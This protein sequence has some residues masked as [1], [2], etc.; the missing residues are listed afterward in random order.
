MSATLDLAHQTRTNCVETPGSDLAQMN[1]TILVSAQRLLYC[2]R[3][4][5][6]SSFGRGLPEIKQLSPEIPILEAEC[7]LTIL[8]LEGSPVPDEGNSANVLSDLTRRCARA[9]GLQDVEALRRDTTVPEPTE[10]D[11]A[12]IMPGDMIHQEAS[13]GLTVH[14]DKRATNAEELGFDPDDFPVPQ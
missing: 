2:Q 6:D 14:S 11:S 4:V 12:S 7:E 10:E 5:A 9:T 13:T 1:R 8:K 3:F